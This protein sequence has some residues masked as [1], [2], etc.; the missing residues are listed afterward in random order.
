MAFEGFKGFF[1]KGK[2]EEKPPE[3]KAPEMMITVKKIPEDS[4][5]A[6][7]TL[8][9][10]TEIINSGDRVGIADTGGVMKFHYIYQGISPEGEV[11]VFNQKTR[12]RELHDRKMFEA[13]QYSPEAEYGRKIP[14]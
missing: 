12:Q 6:R 2:E 8:H 4:E 10:G 1:G 5:I 9:I 11:V 7:E 14:Q 13:L 3:K